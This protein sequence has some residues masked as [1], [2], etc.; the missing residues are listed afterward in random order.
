[1]AMFGYVGL[2][3]AIQGYVWLYM[4]MYGYVGLGYVGLCRT[5]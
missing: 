5:M 4:A 3:R 1:M 2:Y